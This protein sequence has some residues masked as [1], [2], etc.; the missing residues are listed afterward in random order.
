VSSKYAIFAPT[1]PSS[2]ASQVNIQSRLAK[3]LF[4]IIFGCL[5]ISQTFATCH[6]VTPSGSGSK[7]GTDW[8]N[9]YAGLPPT[10]VRGDIYYLGDGS[11]GAVTLSTPTSGTTTI[12]IRKAQSY[13]NCTSTGWNTST[14]GSSQAVFSKTSPAALSINTNYWIIN[15]NGKQTNPGCGG[16]PNTPT[17][18]PSNPSDC[19]IRVD[20]SSCTGSGASACNADAISMTALAAQTL[21][22][23]YLEVVDNGNNSIAPG[24]IGFFRGSGGQTFTHLYG[25]NAGCVF[26]IPVGNFQTVSFS[27]FWVTNTSA[28]DTCHPQYESNFGTNSNDT[29][30]DNVYRDINGSSVFTYQDPGSGPHTNM[31]YYNNVFWET[32]G[33]PY[34]TSG[35]DDGVWGVLQGTMV[36]AVMYQNTFINLS[37]YST[38]FY[39]ASPGQSAT[40]ENNLVYNSSNFSFGNLTGTEDYNSILNSGSVGK[41]SHDMIVTSNAPNPFVSWTTG[42]FKLAATNADWN[43]GNG[44]LGAPYTVDPSGVV[45]STLTGAYG[46]A[47]STAPAPPTNLTSTVS[48]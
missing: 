27:Y 14:M 10:M 39:A 32:S 42:A 20:S 48:P 3:A 46:L 40:F 29:Q 37:G 33:H 44:A 7:M 34:T 41:G 45:H 31:V 19:G 36:N 2:F 22:F 23:K 6:V 17:T 25:R 4:L 38:G 30:H 8:N 35:L 21:T 13:D 28:A 26:F 12:E 15:G 9:A 5:S 43:N 16:T 24:T 11:Y 47:N 18:E 1:G